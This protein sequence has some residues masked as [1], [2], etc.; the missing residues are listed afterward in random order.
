[1]RFMQR[2]S[3]KSI[4]RFLPAKA[5]TMIFLS[6]AVKWYRPIT[7]SS[8][9]LYR[10]LMFSEE[11]I[12]RSTFFIILSCSFAETMGIGTCSM[13][14]RS[15]LTELNFFEIKKA[16]T[17]ELSIAR[18]YF[19]ASPSISGITILQLFKESVCLLS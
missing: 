12:K 11:F 2:A 15:N 1:M 19:I 16:T 17:L 10:P 8:N 9:S 6:W 5:A 13:C 18:T 14:E 4:N 3:Q 7:M